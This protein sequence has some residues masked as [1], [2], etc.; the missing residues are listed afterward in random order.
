MSKAWNRIRRQVAL[1]IAALLA[2]QLFS[3]IGAGNLA[4]AAI[5]ADAFAD[6][7]GGESQWVVAGSFTD[8]NEKPATSAGKMKHLVGGFYAFS[9]V[10]PAGTHEFKLTQNGTWDGFSNGGNNFSLTLGEETKVNFYVNEEI[11]QARVTAPGVSGLPQYAASLGDDKWPRLVGSLQT[12]LGETADWSPST[13]ALRFVDYNFDGSVYKYQAT[14]PQG[15]YEAKVAFGPSWD[16]SYGDGGGN[17]ALDIPDEA[18]TIFT[19]DY[20]GQNRQLGAK[21]V[22]QSG[23]FDGKV[24]KSGIRFDSRS[25]TFKKPFGA[26]KEGTEDLTLRVAASKDDVQLARVELTDGEGMAR[27]FDMRKTTSVSG[28]DYFEAVIPARTFTPIG[29]WGY[30]F[31]LIDGAAK[32]ELGDDKNGN[33]ARGGSG[34]VSDEGAVPFDLTVYSADYHTP[35]WMKEAVVYQIFPDRF[36]DGDETNNRAKVV[37]GYRGNRSESDDTNAI[38][39]YKLQYF[40]GGVANEPAP[41]QVA[42]DWRDV[43]ENPDRVK[44]ENQP[45]YPGAKTDGV[46]TNEF[47]GG[48]LQGVQQKLG[49]LKSI[50]VNTIYFNPI[51]W[52]ASNHK[53]DATDYKH[54][55]PMFGEPVYNTPGDPTSGL[56]YE[57]TRVASDKVFIDFAKAAKA[58][59]IRIIGDGVFNHVGDDSVY[60]DRY[61]KYP[62]IGAYEYWARVYDIANAAPGKTLDQAKSEAQAYYT[63]QKNP[64]TG[65]NYKYPEDFAYTTWF[66]IENEKV[67]DRDGTNTHYKYDAWWGYDSL[68][69]MDAVTPQAGDAD[70]I[71]GPQEAHEWNNI[72]YRDEVIGHDLAGKNEADAEAAM[73]NVVSQRW[74]WMGTSGWRLD[75]APDVSAGTWKKFREAVKST[76]GLKDASGD[77]I[78]EPIILGEEWNVATPYLLGD[79]FDSVMNYRFRG[80]LQTFMIGGDAKA[81]N[82]TLESIREDYP[83]EAWQVMLNLMDSHD[84]T[85]SITKLDFPSYEEEHLIIAPEA[86]DKALKQQALVALFQLGYPGAPTIYYGDEVGLTGTKDPDSRRTFPWERVKE[87]EGTYTGTGRYSDLFGTYQ[88]AAA[89]R[90]ANDVFSTGDLKTA[91]AD[92][93]VIAYAR[94]TA[95]KGGLTAINRADTAREFEADVTGFLPDGLKLKDELG[96]AIEATVQSGKLR[97]TLPAQSGVMMVSTG[98]LGTVAEVQGVTAAAGNGKVDLSWQAVP[99][100]AGY[101]V[102]RALIEGGALTRVGEVEAGT[103]AFADRTGIVN[104]TKY[105]YAVTAYAGQSESLIG[106][107]VS[108]TPFYPIQSVSVPSSVAGVVYAGVGKKIEGITVEVT[109][110]GLTD[111]GAYTGKAAPNLPGKLF[112]YPENGGSADAIGVPLKYK[113]DAGAAKV[114]RASF[115]PTAAGLYRYYAAFS[116]DNEETWTLSGENEVNVL[117]SDDDLEAPDAPALG[118]LLQESG[119]ASL[120][121]TSDDGSVAG[122]EIYRQSV[123]DAVYRK[124]ATVAKEARTYTDFTVNNDMTYTYRV[125]AY[126]QAYNRAYSAPQTVTPRLV[127][128]D[129][130]LRLHLPDYTPTTDDITIAGDFNGWNVSSTKLLVPSGATTREVVEYSFKMMAGKAIQYKYARGDWNKEAFTSHSR[131]QN[132]TTDP[133]NWAYSSTDTNM[134]LKIANQGGNKMIVDDYV[135][136]WVD[137]PVAIYQPRKSYGEDIAYSTT[138]ASFALRAAVPYGVAFTINGKPISEGAMD[139]YGNVLVN[140]IPLAQG[141]NVFTLHI[142][143]T[144]ET[145]NLPFYTDKG[146]ASQATK[147]IKLEIT[148]TGGGTESPSPEP[149]TSPSPEPTPVNNGP[150]P[151]P[152]PTSA[153]AELRIAADK[154]VPDAGGVVKLEIPA[155]A[156]RILLPA[157]AGE[158][159]KSGV[160]TLVKEGLSLSVPAGLLSQAAG[161]GDKAAQLALDIA[162]LGASQADALIAK[163]ER[164]GRHV[165]I[166]GEV[167]NFA[168][169]V[170][171]ED[172]K[173]RVVHELSPPVKLSIRADANADRA[174]AGLYYV[175]DDGKLEYVRGT[176]SDDDV[177]TAYVTHFSKY[178]LLQ[179]DAAFADVP[180][181]HWA[182][183]AVRSLAAKQIVNGTD[184]SRY[185]PARGVTRAEFAAMLSRALG[186]AAPQQKAPFADVAS[187]AWYEDAVSAAAEAGIVSGRSASAFAPNEGITREE[188]A[189]MLM[190]AYDYAD[191]AG[192]DRVSAAAAEPFADASGFSAWASEAIGRAAGLGL[193]SGRDGHVFAA[194]SGL[195]RAESAQ[196]LFRL[197]GL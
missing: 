164:E 48:D 104:A 158:L 182:W 150:T 149:S 116:S 166:V 34:V 91:Y 107:M 103:L 98:D 124:I 29:V 68:P 168:L 70:A 3:G 126:D 157:S 95:S 77:T 169:S 132:D 121:W 26:I 144:A 114:Y 156:T 78:D 74:V 32:V 69:A 40:D 94:K 31:I 178:A 93:D 106:T 9:T 1:I 110:P 119:R 151:T 187:G 15:R 113:E 38:E 154:L 14:I 42:G 19:I 163:A 161:S 138:D 46:W 139:A 22:L 71:G 41:G 134:Q 155:G 136:R 92:G 123:T 25:L 66:T 16:E 54:L 17:L 177:L 53:Y 181:G 90:H 72:A 8:W 129:V 18:Y 83:K 80:A 5:T 148:R 56:N 35:D 189:V 76:A 105:Y 10:L 140:D 13:S 125:A 84:T 2:L 30:K 27:T 62:E 162:P 52:A 135:L 50:G 67:P 165:R 153:P 44:P 191:D 81:F 160:L 120:A 12:A 59:G 88:Q 109:V 28:S 82:E 7:P 111:N 24:D 133:G 179:I 174:V 64:K 188:M 4:S 11:G 117:Q 173:S 101:R 176:W 100:A 127:M 170:I 86:S 193:L 49:Y 131:L 115:E 63:S 122:F 6:Q 141:K 194:K 61:E 184:A 39:P 96:G 197:L 175:D 73:Q 99:G 60:F 171:G 85:R 159:L 51:A 37:D 190:R 45:Y 36:F 87:S 192:A 118:G 143:P 33:I 183:T 108:A 186:L 58:Q 152:A 146:R 196:A 172:G 142:E 47:Y 23:G 89:V 167:Y 185:E 112:Y 130:T 20:K 79:Q 180:T 128:I 75:V 137:M 147:T 97:L 55:D 57:A 102:Y 21:S 145:L 65:K 43:P 195:T